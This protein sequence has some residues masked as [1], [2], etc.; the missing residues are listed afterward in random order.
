MNKLYNAIYQWTYSMY[1]WGYNLTHLL[2]EMHPKLL[3]MF[4]PSI[5]Y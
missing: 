4:F 5:T 2:S 1:R 3:H